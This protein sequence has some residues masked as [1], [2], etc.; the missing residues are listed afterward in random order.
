MCG[1]FAFYSPKEAITRLFDVELPLTI[2]PHFNIA[3]SQSIL[4]LR[5]EYDGSIQPVMMR[6]GLVP[7]WAKDQR[8]GSRLI[9]ARSETV[10]QKPAFRAA[11]KHR[12]CV[13]LADGFF[14]WR[15]A[16][17]RKVPFYIRMKNGEPFAMA[18]LWERWG[19]A[20][21]PLETCTIITMP[22][23]RALAPLH[24]RMP[25]IVPPESLRRWIDP[26][27]KSTSALHGMFEERAD[28]ALDYWEVSPDVN[29]PRNDSPQLIDRYPPIPAPE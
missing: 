29:N 18:G 8:I 17:D 28:D 22:A 10:H 26:M 13:I 2:E 16:E 14:E 11:F 12:R 1:R 21:S 15:K 7:F 9:N 20:D 19:A 4:V 3:P 27:D 5:H 6:W 24:H 23:S 25:V